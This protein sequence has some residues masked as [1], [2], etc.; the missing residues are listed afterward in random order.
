MLVDYNGISYTIPRDIYESDN[1]YFQRIWFVAKQEPRTKKQ[2]DECIYNSILW[3]NIK[4][5]HCKYSDD[6]HTKITEIEDKYL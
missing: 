2:L 5:M 1:I 3:K 4:F 6:V